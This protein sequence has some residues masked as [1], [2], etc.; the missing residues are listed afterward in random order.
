MN[1]VS[2][3]GRR[4]ADRYGM[5]KVRKAGPVRRA[6]G[7]LSRLDGG[8]AEIFAALM[9]M[10]KGYRIIG[11]RVPT[12]LG[13]IDIVAVRRQTLAVI[14]VKRRRTLV[15]AMDAV[16]PAQ[17][18]YLR[19]VGKQIS[20]T[21]IGLRDFSVRLDLIAVAPGRLPRHIANAWPDDAETR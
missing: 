6:R 2:G 9:L 8:R 4:K 19:Q 15:E 17:R 21:R 3:K 14:E 16:S 10:L 13:E 5:V 11:F 20:T 7:Q 12:S 1:E 18:Y